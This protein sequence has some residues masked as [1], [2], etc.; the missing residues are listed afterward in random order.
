MIPEVDTHCPSAKVL[1]LCLSPSFGGLEMHVRDYVRWIA[2]HAPQRL[3]LGLRPGSPLQRELADLDAP[4]WLGLPSLRNAGA[5]KRFCAHAGVGVLHAHDQRDTPLAALTGWRANLRLVLTRHMAM[6]GSKKD[7]YHAL[8]YRQVDA[9]VAV[10]EWVARQAR[11]RLPIASERVLCIH[12]GVRAPV[13]VER[14]AGDGSFRAGMVGR[15]L[16]DKGQHLLLAAAARLRARGVPVSVTLAGEIHDEAYFEV[17]TAEAARGRVPLR[18]LGFV[19]PPAKAF[20]QLDVAVV[21]SREEAFGLST[22]DALRCGVPVLATASGAGPEIIRDGVDGLLFAPEDPA[23]LADGLE[24][25]FRDPAAAQK[26][27]A[28]GRERAAREFDADTQFGK[29]WALVAA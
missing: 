5:L 25:V 14:D 24:R 6:G 28:D 29:S 13:A 17:L 8:I 2:A 27:A 26:M 7:P 23:A 21:A 9:Y 19:S 22:V 11:E 4:R 20:A 1:V 15:I 3:A 12:P 10:S 18:H 16:P